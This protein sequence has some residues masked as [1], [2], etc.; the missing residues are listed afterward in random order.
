[1]RKN[2]SASSSS[3]DPEPE[4]LSFKIILV[5]NHAVG[6]TNII[7]RYCEDFFNKN[8]KKTIGVDFFQKRLELLNDVNV[9]LQIWDIDGSAISGKMLDTYVHDVNAIIFTYDVTEK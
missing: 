7:G 8:Y 3:D 6:K 4:N 9:N 2:S 1:M 5:G